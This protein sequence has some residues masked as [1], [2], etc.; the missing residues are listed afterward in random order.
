MKKLPVL[1]LAILALGVLTAVAK[2]R[3]G[4]TDEDIRKADYLYLE[5]LRVKSQ[6]QGDAAFDLLMRARELNPDDEEIGEELSGY[7]LSISSGDSLVVSQ[8]VDM[9]RICNFA[10]F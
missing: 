7:V 1:I 5:A 3:R 6:G 9:M 4:P 10:T 8:G 2:N